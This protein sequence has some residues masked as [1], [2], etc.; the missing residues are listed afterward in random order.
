[1]SPLDN[2]A[3]EIVNEMR[4]LGAVFEV[5]PGENGEPTFVWRARPASLR[6]TVRSYWDAADKPV[7]LKGAMAR[8]IAYQGNGL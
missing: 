1:M 3:L 7:G 2:K 5:E 4:A 8:I 6:D